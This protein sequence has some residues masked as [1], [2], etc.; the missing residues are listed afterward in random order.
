MAKSIKKEYESLL[1][2]Y[3]FIKRELSTLPIGYIS[4]KSINGKEQYYLQHRLGKKV[5]SVYIKDK[6]IYSKYAGTDVKLDGDEYIIVKHSDILAI[7]K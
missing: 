1:S 2:R 3:Q 6:V 7:V 4:K 5:V